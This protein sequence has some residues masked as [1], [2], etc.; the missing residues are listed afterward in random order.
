MQA[1]ALGIGVSA[2]VM[3]DT[4]L[5]LA[6]VAF[7]FENLEVALY[8]VVRRLAEHAGDGDTAAMAERILEEE[9]G[10]GASGLQGQTGRRLAGPAASR[11][12]SRQGEQLASP[13]PGYPAETTRP[14]GEE[15]PDPEHP[16]RIGST[17]AGKDSAFLAAR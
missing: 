10:G 3:P 15:I 16:E 5:R 2:M 11:R 7:A 8:S 12:R 13:E 9:E 6:V 4:T 1:S 14:Y 17:V